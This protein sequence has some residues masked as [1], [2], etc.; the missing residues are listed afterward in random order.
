MILYWGQKKRHLKAL[1][2]DGIVR[3]KCDQPSKAFLLSCTDVFV[4]LSRIPC[5]TYL[6][7]T[8][9]YC[10]NHQAVTYLGSVLNPKPPYTWTEE[11]AS[12]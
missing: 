6:E 10:V 11:A 5:L 8:L 12:L 7:I 2:L 1:Q 4:A 9:W 3:R